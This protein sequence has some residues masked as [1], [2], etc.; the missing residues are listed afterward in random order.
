VSDGTKSGS[1]LKSIPIGDLVPNGYNPNHMSAGEFDEYVA[2][3]EHLGR[4][5]K[6]IVVR[7]QNHGKFEIVDGEHGWRAAKKLGFDEVSCEVLENV[8]DFEAMRQTFKRNRGGHDN[9]VLLGRMFREM[10]NK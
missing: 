1:E 5:S 3:V 8:D 9:P 10:L 2:E 6:P 4:L 7:R